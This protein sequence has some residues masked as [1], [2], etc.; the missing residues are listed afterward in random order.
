[1]YI[2]EAVWKTTSSAPF[3]AVA[4]ERGQRL[5]VVALHHLR[6]LAPRHLDRVVGAARGAPSGRPRIEGAEQPGA[7]VGGHVDGAQVDAAPPRHRHL[8]RR[9]AARRGSGMRSSPRELE[10]ARSPRAPRVREAVA[11]PDR[12][13]RPADAPSSSRSSGQPSPHRQERRQQ[14][15]RTLHLVRL[16]VLLDHPAWSRNSQG[17]ARARR[18]RRPAAPRRASTR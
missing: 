8:A 11:V 7:G 10:V 17:A 15:P 18:R 5:D 6:R 12:R 1:M 14:R 2:V 13:F 9:G 4:N 16:H 3:A